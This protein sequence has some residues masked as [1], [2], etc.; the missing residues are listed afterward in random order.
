MNRLIRAALLAEVGLSCELAH[1]HKVADHVILGK[2]G[3]RF[4][5]RSSRFQER[6]SSP[7]P[8]ERLERSER[9]E[10][11][12]GEPNKVGT[13][14][15]RK[16]RREREVGSHAVL[17]QIE[18]I[19]SSHKCFYISQTWW[20]GGFAAAGQMLAAHERG[21]LQAT[22]PSLGSSGQHLCSR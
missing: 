10:G 6:G 12:H 20:S 11:T 19:T 5:T 16:R 7:G 9:D 4:E 1:N 22:G 15:Q 21:R 17:L 2:H 18:R 8:F 13:K 3:C 14:L